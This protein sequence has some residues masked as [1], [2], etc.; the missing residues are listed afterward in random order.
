[1]PIPQ[2]TQDGLLPVGVHDASLAEIQ[3]RFGI[4]TARR[5]ELFT[6]LGQFEAFAKGYGL[7]T[8]LYVDGSFCTSKDE[9][10]DIDGVL[11]MPRSNLAQLLAHP[12]GNQVLDSAGVKARF[13]FH[14]F[15]MPP[16]PVPADRDMVDF[17]QRIKPE[18]ALL[19]NVPKTTRRGILRV[20]L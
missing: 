3:A 16:P 17:F 5:V 8:F 2:L 18:D 20:K 12:M 1:M 11:E 19:L 4:R 14:L 9:P 7:F 13:E 10:G 15:L 6:K